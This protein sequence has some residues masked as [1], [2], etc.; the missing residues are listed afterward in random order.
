MR[1][2]T[3]RRAA[4]SLQLTVVSLRQRRHK[5]PAARCRSGLK[6]EDVEC[7]AFGRVRDDLFADI[8]KEGGKRNRPSG[9]DRDILL[10]VNLVGDRSRTDAAAE[11]DLPKLLPRLGIE[12]PEETVQ[13][14]PEDEIAAGRSQLSPVRVSV[15]GSPGPGTIQVFQ[16]S[17]PALAS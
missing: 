3:G 5:A 7:A 8:A 9:N 15:P 2:S 16:T 17:L 13:V 4:A 14:T 6:R 10:A 12:G 1:G 11:L